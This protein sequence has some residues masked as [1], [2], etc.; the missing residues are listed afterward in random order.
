MHISSVCNLNVSKECL[1]VSKENNFCTTNKMHN[2]TTY[3][4]VL[5]IIFLYS[6]Y[7]CLFKCSFWFT[8]L[9]TDNTL[10]KISQNVLVR[11]LVFVSDCKVKLAGHLQNLVRQCPVANCYF[12]RCTALYSRLGLG[13]WKV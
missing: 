7:V 4:A 2:K 13:I 3:T 10:K 8:N 1:N 6:K 5:E 12:Q 11:C 9:L